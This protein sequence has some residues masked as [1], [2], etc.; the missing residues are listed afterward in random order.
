CQRDIKPESLLITEGGTLKITDF[1]LA[2]VQDE[3]AAGYRIDTSPIPLAEI[4]DDPLL[5]W[6]RVAVAEPEPP[7]NDLVPR[8]QPVSYPPELDD[9]LATGD[10]SDTSLPPEEDQGF[11]GGWSP[12]ELVEETIDVAPAFPAGLPPRGQ[13][14]ETV[15]HDS[16][17]LDLGTQGVTRAG[18]ML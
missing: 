17:P 8:S 15:D 9:P 5:S 7:A 1:G 16:R 14:E 18:A 2:K 13:F 10:W 12:E 11:P 3:A 6:P 4:D